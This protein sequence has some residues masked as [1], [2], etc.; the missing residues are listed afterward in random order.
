MISLLSSESIA[1][2]LAVG[3][4]RIHYWLVNYLTQHFVWYNRSRHTEMR[5]IQFVVIS[6]QREL[7]LFMPSKWINIYRCDIGAVFV[8]YANNNRH[9]CFIGVYLPS[10]IRLNVEWAVLLRCKNS[11]RSNCVGFLNLIKYWWSL[12]ALMFSQSEFSTHTQ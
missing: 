3:R 5:S 7:C 8:I 12:T 11:Y 1:F 9:Y 10:A 6:V 2:S 4:L